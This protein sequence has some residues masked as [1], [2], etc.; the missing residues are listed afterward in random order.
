MAIERGFV[1]TFLFAIGWLAL[2]FHSMP[3]PLA[4]DA[5]VGAIRENA[6]ALDHWSFTPALTTAIDRGGFDN[7][8][9]W[10]EVRPYLISL[11][12][13]LGPRFAVS[14]LLTLLGLAEFWAG[15]RFLAQKKWLPVGIV[16]IVIGPALPCMVARGPAGFLFSGPPLVA[17]LVIAAI[18]LIS[19]RFAQPA[20]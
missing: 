12:E 4:A 13:T 8:R 2:A 1:V 5:D 9:D 16:M 11:D 19:K 7:A 6:D 20:R 3:P 10:M 14:A 18:T 17:G 15:V